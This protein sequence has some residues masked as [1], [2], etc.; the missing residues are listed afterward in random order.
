M[1]PSRL[2][3]RQIEAIRKAAHKAV[4]AD[5]LAI[6][7]KIPAD[8]FWARMG[9]MQLWR[10]EKIYV[11]CAGERCPTITNIGLPKRR[12]STAK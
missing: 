12:N 7:D 5:W 1:R 9:A 11:D 6:L 8:D 4:D 3:K 2:S 10:E